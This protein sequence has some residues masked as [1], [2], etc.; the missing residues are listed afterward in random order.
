LLLVAVATLPITPSSDWKPED[1]S[2]PA[3]RILALLCANVGLPFFL[4]A[5]TSPLLQ[6]W[7]HRMRPAALPYRLYALGNGGSL[8]ALVS[9]PFLVEPLLTRPGRAAAWS[10]GFALFAVASTLCA[11]IVWRRGNLKPLPAAT[12][13][14]ERK[15]AA[16]AARPPSTSTRTLWLLLPATASLLLLAVTH[17]ISQDVAA[18]PFLWI[19]PLVVYLLSFMLVF[20]SSRW[21]RR[22]VF[23]TALAPAMG[24]AVW[25][26]D[27]A[28]HASMAA[29][30]LGWSG[31]LF[32][33]CMVAH[34]ELARLKPHPQRLT[35]FY[36]TVSM[37]GALGGLAAALLA[38]L[39]FNLYLELHLGLWL[40]CTL[41][42][43]SVACGGD[44]PLQGGRRPL[45]WIPVLAA[46]LALTLG[47]QRDIARSHDKAIAITRSF[48]GVLRVN[49]YEAGKPFEAV[50]LI[51]GRTSHGLQ[52]RAPQ[53]R[54]WPTLYY[55]LDSGAGLAFRH[56]AEGR[57]RRVGVVGMGAGTLAFYG[58]AGDQIRFYEI[59]AAVAEIASST[60]TF[61]ADTK[62]D[63]EVVIGDARTTLEREP[64]NGF[65]ILFLDAFSSN[66][67]PAHL[68][69][70]EAFEIYRRHLKPDGVIAVN[71]SS[72]HL[73]LEPLVRRLGDHIGF[74][75]LIINSESDG[76][77]GVSGSQWILLSSNRSFLG[78]AEI[79]SASSPASSRDGEL[80]SDDYANV[81][82][83]LRFMAD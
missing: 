66:A 57:P 75:A 80:W 69:T 45:L 38:P 72:V 53:R 13:K 27:L 20:E 31:V 46:L 82:G 48:H 15:A 6:V 39:V 70:R 40:T 43:V 7:L 71:I 17:Q 1:I 35:G 44:S 2:D 28:G 83:A 22:S 59:D 23:L 77:R 36:L 47:L 51:H 3:W 4:L 60:F 50:A 26:L 5:S 12:S 65:D 30:L 42:L 64:D 25:L 37:G 56:H 52:Y 24:G 61:T 49:L 63:V 62:A 16:R 14:K 11:I 76:I 41:G 55:A 67:I 33:C 79:R 81:L 58:R 74:Q 29:Q 21:Y 18:I 8:L 34:G 32:V 9:Y 73:D 68:L 54:R 78:S 10:G 19:V